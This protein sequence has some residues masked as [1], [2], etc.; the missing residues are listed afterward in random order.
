MRREDDKVLTRLLA[1]GGLRIGEALALRRRNLDP[2]RHTLTIRESATE[3]SGQLVVGT[4]KTSAVRTI[5][6]P[7]SLSAA[8]AAL[9][10]LPGHDAPNR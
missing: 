4:T 1:Y 5:T 9:T 3:V 7:K 2:V 10:E 6:L 8:L